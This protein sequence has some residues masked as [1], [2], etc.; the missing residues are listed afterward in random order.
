VSDRRAWTSHHQRVELMDLHGVNV[1]YVNIQY[2]PLRCILPALLFSGRFLR[3]LPR[4]W[5]GITAQ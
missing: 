1:L 4:I 2:G 5:Y 3:H